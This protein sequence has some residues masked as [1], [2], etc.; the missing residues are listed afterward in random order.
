MNK[1]AKISVNFL[2]LTFTF[3]LLPFNFSLVFATDTNECKWYAAYFD[4]IFVNNYG[5]DN[6]SARFADDVAV[7]VSTIVRL[8]SILKSL[9]RQGK[10]EH[11]KRWL[12]VDDYFKN[13]SVATGSLLIEGKNVYLRLTDSIAINKALKKLW[14]IDDVV[15]SP[16]KKAGMWLFSLH[17]GFSRTL[18]GSRRLA[19]YFKYGERPD[20]NLLWLQCESSG[21]SSHHFSQHETDGYYHMY[22]G[23]YLSKQNVIKAQRLLLEHSNL[24]TIIVS[25]YITAAIIKK[26]AYQ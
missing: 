20:S 4:A 12:L 18:Q 10:L 8:D 21:Y 9:R 25:Q 13:Y 22:T 23:F 1:L 24:K 7:R 16:N 14:H 5:G 15:I 6:R 3:L 17:I 2:L 26:Y 19:H 11:F